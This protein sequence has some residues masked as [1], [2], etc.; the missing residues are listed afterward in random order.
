MFLLKG[1]SDLPLDKTSSASFSAVWD[2]LSY[3]K[4]ISQ[5][6]KF[7]AEAMFRLREEWFDLPKERCWKE[8]DFSY[9]ISNPIQANWQRQL[10]CE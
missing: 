4:K 1:R 10:Y 9:E 3:I 5:S 6:P 7:F 2:K 8:S